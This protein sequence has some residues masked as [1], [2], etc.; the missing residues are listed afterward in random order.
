MYPA[1]V[2]EL[3]WDQKAETALQQIKDKKYPETIKNY[4]GDIL[5]VGISYIKGKKEHQC[6]IEKYPPGFEALQIM[7]ESRE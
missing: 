3:K 4:A 1:M 2:I 5:L 7:K 6:Q